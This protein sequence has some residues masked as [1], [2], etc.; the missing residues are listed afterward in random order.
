MTATRGER[1]VISRWCLLLSCLCLLSVSVASAQAQAQ[2]C[3]AEYTAFDINFESG[4]NWQGCWTLDA[5]AGLTLS[6][7]YYQ[8]P[9]GVLRRAIARLSLGGVILQYDEDD[10]ASELLTEWG[11]TSLTTT[12]GTTPDCQGDILSSYDGQHAICRTQFDAGHLLRYQSRQIKL[13]EGVRFQ[14]SASLGSFKWQITYEL[15]EDGTIRP[16]TTLSGRIGRFTDRADFGNDVLGDDADTAIKPFAATATLLTN[17]R[18]D[19]SIGEDA[20]NDTVEQFDF[21][22]DNTSFDRRVMTQQQLNVETLRQ[23]DPERFRKWR[24][25]DADTSAST[26]GVNE[27]RVGYLLDPQ[28]QS[29]RYRSNTTNFAQ[30]DLMVTVRK[31]CEQFI[32]NNQSVHPDCTD[33]LDGFIN[34]QLLANQDPV[35]WF[36]LT[37]RLDPTLNDWP[38]LQP[39]KS[40]LSLIPFDWSERS[41]FEEVE[42]P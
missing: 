1:I 28:P 11:L 35:L 18:I 33:S 30:F 7:V 5:T 2:S 40:Q 19:L 21:R 37:R 10:R 29:Y 13:Q 25:Y 8:T 4:A 36:S 16:G 17:W 6:D 12:D 38:T 23:T 31:D 20:Q 41:P 32:L 27:T 3:Q 14:H 34:G 26:D 22:S 9:G 24:L 39:R 15:L 42:A